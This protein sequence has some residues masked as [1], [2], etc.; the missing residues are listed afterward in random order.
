MFLCA[1]IDTVPLRAAVEVDGSEGVFR[2]R[3]DAI[4]GADNKAAVAVFL[5]AA[6]RW[7]ARRPPVGVELLFTT[8]EETGL[9]GAKAF[10]RERLRADFGYVYDH[11]SPI[12]GLVVA[13]PTHYAIRADFLGRAAHAGIRPEAG[14]NAIVAAAQA[15]GRI[16][17]GRIDPETTL[18]VGVISGGTAGNV[19]AERCRVEI[20]VRSLDDQ[21]ASDL[22]SQVVDACTWAASATETDVDAHVEE[23]FRA[24]RI[25]DGHP[26]VEV[27][28]GALRDCGVE[29]V[30][31]P[32]GGGSDASVFE[33]RGL[34]CLNVANGTEANHASEEQVTVR[35]LETML[36][37][38]F[39]LAERAGAAPA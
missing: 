7:A 31:H 14:R 24:Y 27:A 23:H 38:T 20:E 36:D 11:A 33:E 15:I 22:V 32:S 39:R 28:S 30:L 1:H 4:L 26:C 18:N 12:G 2:N 29:P 21:K 16:P 35:A 37:V 13:A 3:N 10:D 17:S 6:R 34:R 5:Q 8:S 25:P 9:R 19:V